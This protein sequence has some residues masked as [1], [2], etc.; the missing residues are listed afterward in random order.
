MTA[1]Q[2]VSRGL[3]P[4]AF[5][6]CLV[7]AALIVLGMFNG[8]LGANPIE[9]ITHRTGKTT[10]TLLL[11]TLSVTPV[12][13]LTGIGALISL[14][15]MLGLFAFFYV[16][17]HFSI[18]VLDQASY[19]PGVLEDIARRPYVTV[20][21]ASFL[22]LIP[23]AFTSTRGWV[24][25]LGGRRWNRLHRLIY[26]AAAGGVLH[27]LWLVKIDKRTPIVYGLILVTLLSARLVRK[28]RRRP[29]P[30]SGEIA[31]PVPGA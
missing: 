18:Y 24:K 8:G 30:P 16:C 22:L 9:E 17:I 27:F 12:R 1:G 10:L 11:I 3:K 2:W 31:A 21:F 6:A 29:A 28:R 25:R 5:V 20:G 23:L 15:R 26:V 7:P 14:R 13:R 4:A 19:L